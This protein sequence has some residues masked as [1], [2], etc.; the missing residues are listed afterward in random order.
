MQ[1]AGPGRV[2]AIPGLPSLVGGYL[3]WWELNVKVSLIGVHSRARSRGLRLFT[4]CQH[5][6]GWDGRSL[7]RGDS[8][9]LPFPE[10]ISGW[11]LAVEGCGQPSS[12]SAC[13][14]RVARPEGSPAAVGSGTG[15]ACVPV[16]TL[17]S[18]LLPS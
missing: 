6:V 10:S 18:S 12:S 9:G 14:P 3:V 8:G 5:A 16:G 17:S 4:V 15:P 2:E 1:E 7:E 11:W 13:V